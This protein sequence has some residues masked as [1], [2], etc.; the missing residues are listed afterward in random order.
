MKPKTIT[1]SNTAYDIREAERYRC[2]AAN[3]QM[4]RHLTVGDRCLQFKIQNIYI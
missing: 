2:V 3:A 1:N 4:G